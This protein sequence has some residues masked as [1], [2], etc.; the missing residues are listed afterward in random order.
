MGLTAFSNVVQQVPDD[1][2]AWANVAAIHIHNKN[3]ES[4][5]P[6][7]C[8]SL[9]NRRNNWRVWVNKLYCCMDLAKYD[10]AVQAIDV[11]VDFKTQRSTMADIPDLDE[12]V[13]RALVNATIG[14]LEEAAK[15]KVSRREREMRPM[16]ET[17]KKKK[18]PL[19][20]PTSHSTKKTKTG[21]KGWTLCEQ[22]EKLFASG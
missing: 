18:T 13:V 3:P 4:A 1:C 9:K 19:Y 14:L 16:S 17:K 10:E 21:G 20:L 8:E 6:A 15:E 12:K 2:D 5:Y 7:L 11:L 22:D